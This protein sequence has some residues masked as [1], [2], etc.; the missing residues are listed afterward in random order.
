MR[1]VEHVGLTHHCVWYSDIESSESECVL[2]VRVHVHVCRVSYT[3]GMFMCV[4]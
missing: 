2:G 1:V 3:R 4:V